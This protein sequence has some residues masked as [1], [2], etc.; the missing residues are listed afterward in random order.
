[1]FFGE[2]NTVNTQGQGT[3]SSDQYSQGQGF[4]D[5]IKDLKTAF[6]NYVF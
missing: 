1:M 5:Q 3:A 4:I 2:N 6:E